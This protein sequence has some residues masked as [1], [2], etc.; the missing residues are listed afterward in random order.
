MDTLSLE[1]VN[2]LKAQLRQETQK[3]DKVSKYIHT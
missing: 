3:L 2:E 1:V